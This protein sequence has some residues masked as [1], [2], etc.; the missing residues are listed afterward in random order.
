MAFFLLH[1]GQPS[2]KRLARRVVRLR[3]Y[4]ASNGVTH[5]DVVIRWGNSPESD[6]AAGLVLNPREAVL[7]TVSRVQM[8]RLLRRVGVRFA[9]RSQLSG[10]GPSA[11][12]F[13]RHYRVPVFDMRPLACFRSD[14]SPVWM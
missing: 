10:T 6:P 14:A 11:V 4:R 3:N 2:A 8:G 9:D 5:A 7:R 12:R 1:A 13:L